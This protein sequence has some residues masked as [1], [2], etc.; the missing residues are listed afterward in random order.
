MLYLRVSTVDQT[1][2]N[3]ERELRQIGGTN[4]WIIPVRTHERGLARSTPSMIFPVGA[5]VLRAAVPQRPIC[6]TSKPRSASF[7]VV[8]TSW[9][10]TASYGAGT[11]TWKG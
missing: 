1:T 9:E 7:A 5:S 11:K 10:R 3:Q 2:A 4:R 8:M 6:A